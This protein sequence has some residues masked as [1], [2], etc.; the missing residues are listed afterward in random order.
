MR[1]DSWYFEQLV[2]YI[3]TGK[4]LK[5]ISEIMQETQTEVFEPEE[6]KKRSWVEWFGSDEAIQW[7]FLLFG[8]A[9]IVII[10]AR[11]QFSTD[12]ICCG[13]WDGYYHI[14][15]ST[16]LWEN[17]SHFKWLPEFKWLPL[18]V[19]NPQDYDDH[20]FLFHLLQI[21]FLWFFEPVMASKVAAVVFGSLAIFSVYWMM[22]RYKLDH[23]LLWLGALLT[24]ANPFFYRMNMAKAPPL[25]IIYTVLGVYLLF[26]RK[27]IWLLPLMFLFVWTYSL[28][29]MLW[30]A[31]LVWTLIL[32]WNERRFEWRPLTYTT[33]GMVAGNLINPYFPNNFKLFFEHVFT[34]VSSGDYVVGVGG[35]WYPYTGWE[36]ITHL[37]IAMIAMLV[38]YILFG[39]RDGKLPEKAT[40]FLVFTSV[41]FL[42]MFRS[43]RYAEYFPP[44]AILFAAFSWQAFWLPRVVELPD[45]F[46]R[47]LEGFLDVEEKGAGY[48]PWSIPK[49]IVAAGIGLG[50][51]LLMFHNYIGYDLGHGIKQE[52]LITSIKN[53]EKADKH[54]RAMAWMNEN[55]PENELIFNADWDDFPKMFFFDQKHRYVSGLDP[56]YLFSK[57]PDLSRLFDDITNGKHEDPALIIREKFG[58]NY[59]FSD[60]KRHADMYAKMMESGWVE[61]VYEDDEDYILK[62]RAEKGDPPAEAKPAPDDASDEPTPEEIQAA[63]AEEEDNTLDEPDDNLSEEGNNAPKEPNK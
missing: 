25:T 32:A 57:N 10:M 14:R 8:L 6:P 21:P 15:W 46:R 51:L 38:G 61:K 7:V 50:F 1:G 4:I 9:I 45:H 13:D 22:F 31:A 42:A 58:A 24:C 5:E 55:V 34:K 53:N 30:G 63:E 27:Y 48:D 23:L 26:Q 11:L 62:I 12:A 35:E 16:L 56:T 39:P 28:F 17:F 49:K 18:T 41:L 19:L 29:P 44:M 40:F 43:K 52:G 54:R 60:I 3:Y 37:T 2:S 36:L 47:D 33:I 59:I 20:H